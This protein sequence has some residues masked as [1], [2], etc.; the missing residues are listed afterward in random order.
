MVNL[1]QSA[2][3]AVPGMLQNAGLSYDPSNMISEAKNNSSSGS[4]DDLFHLRSS[5]FE[6]NHSDRVSY[7]E[8]KA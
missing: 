7:D 2:Q 3:H 4:S 1:G 6:I 8:G 5:S